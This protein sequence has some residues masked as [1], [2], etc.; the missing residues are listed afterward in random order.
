MKTP[1]AKTYVSVVKVID[2]PLQTIRTEARLQ[3]DKATF[4]LH[5]TLYIIHFA[6]F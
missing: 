1:E 5:C 4:I 2:T 6:F 3:I